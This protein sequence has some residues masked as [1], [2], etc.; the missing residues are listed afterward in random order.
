MFAA[1]IRS[2]YITRVSVAREQP[3]AFSHKHHAFELGI[4]CRYCHTSVE[5]SGFA[6][7]PP[8]HTCMSCHSQIWVNSP[9]LEP[10]RLSYRT[11]ESLQ[12]TR[13]HDLPNFVYFNHSIHIHK[14]IGC[15]TCHG[16]IDQMNITYK[17]NSLYMEWCLNCHR[18]PEQFIRPREEVFNMHY[19]P[20]E[21][22]A[23]LGAR[24]VKEYH[25]QKLLDCYT[26]HR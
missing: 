4:D 12:W 23:V 19:V 24:L 3:V 17:A 13:V 11:N 1:I 5:T 20:K 26:C 14:G 21:D 2:P 25:V 8:T 6:G 10:V 22:Q 15:T 7:I 18:N 9:M 16:P